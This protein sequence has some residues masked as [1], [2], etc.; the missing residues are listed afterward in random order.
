MTDQY[1][2]HC[3]APLQGDGQSCGCG[4]N[5]NDYEA[6]SHHLSAGTLLRKRYLVGKAIGEGGF[7][8]TYIGR[9][10]VLK[11]RVAI[12]EYYPNGYSNRNHE[13]S[14]RVTLGKT[15][16]KENWFSRGME[17]FLQ[18]AQTLAQFYEEPGVVG[19]RDFFEENGTAYIVMDYLDGVTMKEYIQRK[20]PISPGKLFELLEPVMTALEKIH[21]A[22]LIHRD[23][24]PDNLML[25]RNGMVK[26][27]DFGAVRDV[28]AD[29]SLSVVLKPGY[30]PEEQYRTKGQQGPWTDVY[31]LCATI[32]KCITGITPDESL[33]RVYEDSLKAP[34][35]LGV[36]ISPKQEQALLQGLRVRRSE[37]I[38][39][40]N[41]LRQGLMAVSDDEPPRSIHVQRQVEDDEEKTVYQTPE[42]STATTEEEEKTLYQAEFQ[43]YGQPEEEEKTVYQQPEEKADT[44]Q[45]TGTESADS[46]KNGK[47]E[48]KSTVRKEKAPAEKVR[49]ERGKKTKVLPLIIGGAVAVL[50]LVLVLSLSL[51]KGREKITTVEGTDAYGL[52][53]VGWLEDDDR[54]IE[55]TEQSLRDA[56][57]EKGVFEL[58]NYA[59]EPM[60]PEGAGC[61][62]VEY[63]GY[64]LYAA[65]SSDVLPDG[66]CPEINRVSLV[67]SQG[68]ELIPKGAC[69]IS[70]PYGYEETDSRY[71]IVYYATNQTNNQEEHLV[72]MSEHGSVYG[73]VLENGTMYDGY[74]KVFDL[75]KNQF[76]KGLPEIRK[77]NEVRICGDNLVIGNNRE[78]T[79][80]DPNGKALISGEICG[81]GNGTLVIN[82]DGTYRV[83]DE[84]G[85]QT[86]YAN[87][88]VG[89]VENSQYITLNV[90]GRKKVMDRNGNVIM[91][92]I[93]TSIYEEFNGYFYVSD[94]KKSGL[95]T[96]D[97]RE[98]VP[99]QYEWISLVENDC[100]DGTYFFCKNGNGYTLA[101]ENGIIA[102]NL[103]SM[104]TELVFVEKGDALV[105]N[106]RSYALE[107][108]D[109]RYSKLARALMAVASEENGLYGAYDLYTGT[110]LLNCEYEA[111]TY[112]AGYLYA[113]KNGGW[114]VFKIIHSR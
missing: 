57:G 46:K 81:V 78:A 101:G 44:E 102:T 92:A 37:R 58:L 99:C 33:E 53:L 87:Q 67:N 25:L 22:G 114:E 19:V 104:P 32:Y 31:A 24:S 20:G 4:K 26:L 15:E 84:A 35:A 71:L 50:A 66:I 27:L 17:R 52:E 11:L 61:S 40:M 80:Y 9:D 77:I 100:F 79:M 111:V 62:A 55:M 86:Y 45:V 89:V 90:N 41:A 23:I 56:T 113:Y 106:K 6:P 72:S 49:R 16:D 85:A 103:P 54:S 63:L 95:V 93:Y 28:T 39:D 59:G 70:R 96:V 5:V 30:A 42:E 112:A 18:E 36:S 107:L 64:G 13:M 12:K 65:R 91:D 69:L 60:F 108:G 10:Q 68:E 73:S 83:Y 7:G 1:C 88:Y 21:A 29:K 47:K 110:Q 38:Q 98:L 51:G 2:V 48:K 75:E 76:V 94:G 8:I 105:L 109:R 34:S 97:G 43:E 14:N 3:M 74:I 82:N